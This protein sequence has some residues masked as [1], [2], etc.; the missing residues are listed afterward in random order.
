MDHSNV[1]KLL[2]HLLYSHLPNGSPFLHNDLQCYIASAL[3]TYTFS[4][5]SEAKDIQL[6]VAASFIGQLKTEQEKVGK[7]VGDLTSEDIKVDRQLSKA[8]FALLLSPIGLFTAGHLPFLYLHPLLPIALDYIQA[9]SLR[10]RRS[11][12]YCLVALQNEHNVMGKTE[13]VK[14]SRKLLEQALESYGFVNNGEVGMLRMEWFHRWTL[15][16]TQRYVAL[17]IA[18]RYLIGGLVLI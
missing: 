2:S 5:A 8:A 4:I 3:P 12:R 17:N 16:Q 1:N 13:S 11:L 9:K 6:K 14:P 18:E 15:K 10:Y 7:L